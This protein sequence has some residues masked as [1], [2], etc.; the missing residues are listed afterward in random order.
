MTMSQACEHTIEGNPDG[1][2]LVFIHGWPDNASLWRKQVA[3]LGGTCRC[4]LVTLP[5]FGEQKV[6]SGGFNFPGLVNMLSQTIK[7]VRQDEEQVTLVTHDW[8]AYLGYMLEKTQPGL[9]SNMIAFDIGGHLEP[10][11]ARSRMFILGYQWTLVLF[12]LIGGIVPPLGNGLTWWFSGL[13]KIPER[14]R[15]NIRSRY[16]Y[17][18]F[19]LWRGMLLP[20]HRKDLLGGY[21]PQCPV[22]YVYGRRKPVMFHSEKWLEILGDTG[23][24]SAGIEGAGHWLMET[25]AE[26]VNSMMLDWLTSH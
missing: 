14:Q 5:N 2:T 9:I 24:R 10:A 22:L 12:W 26:Q 7:E 17:P 3:A 16:N 19:Y 18:Y 6:R 4:V 13:L 21:R 11:D 25:N 15:A 1:P 20:W 23:G 8:G